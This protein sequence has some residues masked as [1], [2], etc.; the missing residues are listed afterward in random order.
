MQSAR[1]QWDAATRAAQ[2]AVELSP[3]DRIAADVLAKVKAGQAV[4][5][6]ELDRRIAA[7][8]RE[9]VL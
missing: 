1:G 8:S 2:R 4:D 5:F 3:R 9:R 6:A 7:R